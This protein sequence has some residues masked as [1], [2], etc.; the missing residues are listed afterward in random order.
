M[1][2]QQSPLLLQACHFTVYALQ[3]FFLR[4]HVP[5]EN[6]LVFLIVNRLD[7]RT[8]SLTALMDWLTNSSIRLIDWVAAPSELTDWLTDW[9]HTRADW[10]TG[11]Q[12]DALSD[13]QTKWLT[14]G[15]TD[16]HVLTYRYLSQLADWL[17]DTAHGPYWRE[18]TDW[19]ID[20]PEE[21]LT[22]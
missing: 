19:Q 16:G 4:Q 1:K 3:C 15:L 2:Q 21:R 18:E 7:R 22:N 14:D 11:W 5:T 20:W 17:N 6:I 10:W 12:R 9:Q 13:R 8:D